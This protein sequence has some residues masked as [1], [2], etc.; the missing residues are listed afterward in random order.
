MKINAARAHL[1]V[2]AS[3]AVITAALIILRPAP[4]H[5]AHTL[6]VDMS[7]A[8]PTETL[9]VTLYRGQPVV[10]YF[11]HP[12]NSAYI[13]RDNGHFEIR[14]KDGL[15]GIVPTEIAETGSA[16]FI[17]DKWNIGV[18]LVIV[19]DRDEAVNQVEFRDIDHRIAIGKD[20]FYRP[21]LTPVLPTAPGP[22]QRA[23]ARVTASRSVGPDLYCQVVID[24]R[25]GVPLRIDL[26]GVEAHLG[27]EPVLG[28]QLHLIN[29]PEP[30]ELDEQ[31]RPFVTVMPGQPSH[32]WLMLPG[33][34]ERANLLLSVRLPDLSGEQDLQITVSEWRV[35]EPTSDKIAVEIESLHRFAGT[36]ETVAGPLRA[37]WQR[38]QH[39]LDGIAIITYGS[40]GGLLK[41]EV[42]NSGVETLDYARIQVQDPDENDFT[43]RVRIL[44]RAPEE[45]IGALEPGAKLAGSIRF[46]A[47]KR[48]AQTNLVL[49]LVPRDGTAP[50]KLIFVPPNLGRSALVATGGAGV[51]QLDRGDDG[52]ALTSAY[53]FGGQYIYG[54]SENV[55]LDIGLSV[56][57]SG[58]ADIAD[59]TRSER[60]YR[61]HVGV[62][63]LSGDT[64]WT[65]YVRAGFG[66]ALV[67]ERNGDD[68][69]FALGGSFQGSA[70]IIRYL[71]KSFVMGAEIVGDFAVAG[72]GGIAGMANVFLGITWGEW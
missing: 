41:F 62:R 32:G 26:S 1:L 63:A 27:Q 5:A 55:S 71:A 29:A 68:S 72:S 17:T 67:S 11:P 49:K 39:S 33:A 65:P 24:N 22:A 35:A 54:L 14:G 50:A 30:A 60:L 23:H 34:A 40:D 70:G 58:E 57:S 69:S 42:E 64:G 10:F 13:N 48:L 25:R 16:T 4:A 38:G 37:S 61:L 21:P 9:V 20:L 15:I 56:L 45:G 51:F 46:H 47:P 36:I 43:E 8:K 31:D 53:G 28:T 6:V 66:M 52:S 44:G 12:V 19:A 7:S 59:V 2:T 3:L 18:I